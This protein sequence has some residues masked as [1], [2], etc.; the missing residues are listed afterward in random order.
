MPRTFSFPRAASLVPRCVHLDAVASTNAEL[1]SQGELPP[2]SLLLSTNQTHGR[3]RRSRTWDARP[4][5]CLAISL[6]IPDQ[7]ARSFEASW[8]PLVAGWAVVESLTALG[9]SGATLKWPND[10][11]VSGRKVA[12]ILCELLPSG[13]VIVGVGTNLVFGGEPPTD[14]A[15]ALSDFCVL[16]DDTPDLYLSSLIRSL[17]KVMNLPPEVVVSRVTGVMSTLGNT[18]EVVEPGQASWS[19]RAVGLDADG[20]LIVRDPVGNERVLVAGDVEHVLQ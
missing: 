15:A 14:R 5:E 1:Q 16:N 17:Q 11:L 6:V 3:G 4:G 12:G 9:V 18:V 13:Q 10:V 7:G 2:F 8:V 20:H 19:G